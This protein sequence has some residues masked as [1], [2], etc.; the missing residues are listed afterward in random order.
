MPPL[1][2]DDNGNIKSQRRVSLQ[3]GVTSSGMP[4]LHEMGA[5]AHAADTPPAGGTTTEGGTAAVAWVGGRGS[6]A[7][8]HLVNKDC[9]GERKHGLGDVYADGSHED[10]DEAATLLGSHHGKEQ[11]GLSV[12]DF[13]K[14]VT[15][16]SALYKAIITWA[17]SYD[18]D[19]GHIC[20]SDVICATT[21][22]EKV[23]LTGS[24]FLAGLL[25]ASLS[26]SVVSKC[27]ASRAYLHH[28]WLGTVLDFEPAHDLHTYFGFLT[29][30]AGWAH[31]V[32][33]LARVSYADEKFL[34]YETHAFRSGIF[35]ILLLLPIVLPMRFSFFRNKMTFQFRKR[36]HMLF[37][38]ML[39]ALCFH[40]VVFRY[41]ASILLLWYLID[42]FYFIT[43][44]TFLVSHPTYEAIGRGTMVGIDLPE[45]YT[46]KAGSYIYV[47]CP[48]ID[49]AEWHP[50]SL[51]PV[52]GVTS[53]AAFY[54][55]A[56]G[57]W[58]KDLFRLGLAN[59]S[60]PLW[61]T[62]AQPSLIETTLFYDNVLLIC[63]GAGITP[64][65]AVADRFAAKKNIHLMWIARDHGMMALFE[66]QLRMVTSTVHLTGN[67]DEEIKDAMSKLL[68]RST[69]KFCTKKGKWVGDA[70]AGEL[71]THTS[72][73][74]LTHSS[75]HR[76]GD[77]LQSVFARARQHSQGTML[78]DI[79]DDRTRE[80]TTG[81]GEHGDMPPPVAHDVTLNFGRPDIA[82]FILD[83]LNATPSATL[84]AGIGLSGTGATTGIGAARTS[85]R[86]SGNTANAATKRMDNQVT[87]HL[88]ASQK[89]SRTVLIRASTST[90]ENI[91]KQS[92]DSDNAASRKGRKAP[93]YKPKSFPWIVIY[94]GAN[95][96]VE[97]VIASTCDELNVTW[98]KEYFGGW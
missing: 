57:D 48:A 2:A 34:M 20:P 47:N 75:V 78:S 43:K 4:S 6:D 29:L 71:L 10:E 28:S 93:N 70:E 38:V 35:A 37:L 31:G 95:A 89:K 27:Y 16:A 76:H 65:V 23:M 49:R 94:C 66:K 14:L 24:R 63:T 72:L 55:E 5:D 33:H 21:L 39:V 17:V 30:V 51:I 40:S 58:T 54:A 44:Q 53:R 79:E 88:D 92:R 56:V 61:I 87:E 36:M 13:F 12:F 97:E 59:P 67:P 80:D 42:N 18:R 83:A 26:V 9:Q 46:F 81:W 69:N 73:H 15:L 86:S 11:L 25:Y 19:T 82:K 45:G 85:P 22:P 98:R 52:P 90:V 84:T 32:L 7:P 50:F 3:S 77:S 91:K 62:A 41:V 1:D 96:R 8:S 68:S 74:K 60:Q 64:A